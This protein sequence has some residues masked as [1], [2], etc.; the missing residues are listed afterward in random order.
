MCPAAFSSGGDQR[1]TRLCV[2]G[3]VN[4]DQFFT[5]VALPRPGETVL[6]SSTTVA[7]GGK[8]GNQAVAAARAGVHD[9][10]QQ[11]TPAAEHGVGGVKDAKN[12]VAFGI[13]HI[14]LEPI[15]RV[16]GDLRVVRRL[17]SAERIV[18][19]EPTGRELGR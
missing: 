19:E 5:V 15:D 3:S 17:P 10:A 4:M 12:T 11:I 16:R 8:G 2:V 14:E 13:P 9:L 18:R 1:P 7:P 6:A